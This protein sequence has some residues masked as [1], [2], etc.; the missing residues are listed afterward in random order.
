MQISWTTFQVYFKLSPGAELPIF[1]LNKLP[2][3]FLNCHFKG[4]MYEIVSFLQKQI[5]NFHLTFRS[6]SLGPDTVFS[7]V[8]TGSVSR[9]GRKSYGSATLGATDIERDGERVVSWELPRIQLC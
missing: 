4:K 6:G 7:E 8:G 2:E 9:S 1:M 3:N 5:K